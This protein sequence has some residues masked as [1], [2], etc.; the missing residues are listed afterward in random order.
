MVLRV[1]L[2]SG[3]FLLFSDLAIPRQ[4]VNDIPLP[5]SLRDGAADIFDY[6]SMTTP[7]CPPVL[8][9]YVSHSSRCEPRMSFTRF[10][11]SDRELKYVLSKST[12]AR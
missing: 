6:Y 2:I 11:F 9:R 12:R 10:L 4:F 5:L 8:Q 7:V 3:Q 1:F